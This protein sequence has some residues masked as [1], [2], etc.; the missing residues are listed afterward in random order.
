M[1]ER[2]GCLIGFYHACMHG[3]PFLSVGP[4]SGAS[5]PFGFCDNTHAVHL[6][7]DLGGL[8][9]HLHLQVAQL[10]IHAV[11]PSNGKA[12][13]AC[14]RAEQAHQG[15]MHMLRL[16]ARR[17]MHASMCAGAAS[18]PSHQSATAPS[19]L[20]LISPPYLSRFLHRSERQAPCARG[21]RDGSYKQ[22]G[23]GPLLRRHRCRRLISPSLSLACTYSSQSTSSCAFRK[24][25]TDV[26]LPISHRQLLRPN[27]TAQT[28]RLS[29]QS[30]HRHARRVKLLNGWRVCTWRWGGTGGCVST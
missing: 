18:P 8:L 28:L 16:H 29:E 10:C 9:C 21:W 14:S 23:S 3:F 4:C 17:R 30:L 11:P 19:K 25:V 6:L 26:V 7:P 27:Q 5:S 1:A 13:H 22:R 24:T 15:P 20:L 12:L 2:R